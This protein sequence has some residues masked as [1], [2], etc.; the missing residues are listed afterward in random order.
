MSYELLAL[1]DTNMTAENNMPHL[2]NEAL[3]FQ[4]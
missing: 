4:L 3:A 2:T 1:R